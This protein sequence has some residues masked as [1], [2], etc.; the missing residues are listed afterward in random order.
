MHLLP[1]IASEIEHCRPENLRTDL[2]ALLNITAEQSKSFSAWKLR[3]AQISSAM[4][5][6]ALHGG[7]PG[8]VLLEEHLQ[9]LDEL[10][11]LKNGKQLKAFLHRYANQLLA[12]VSSARHT[13]IEQ[14]VNHIRKKIRN[15][16][17]RPKTLS[18]YARAAGLS[19]GHLSRSFCK[20]AGF[21]F[22]EE[23]R[24]VRMEAARKLLTRTPLKIT[25]IAQRVGLRDA[26]QFIA[27][28][29]LETGVTPGEYRRTHSTYRMK[30][31]K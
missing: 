12:Q 6:G 8:Q 30:L 15:S 1:R 19:T 11:S 23:V 22:R 3:C 25:A 24:R 31:P 5:R 18:E 10:C 26:S 16:L 27:D 29:R 9:I 2:D 20:F 13:N 17:S 28:F 14:A 4:M 21:P 7:A